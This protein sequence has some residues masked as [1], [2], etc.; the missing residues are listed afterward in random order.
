MDKA[1]TYATLL[2]GAAAVISTLAGLAYSSV[3]DRIKR[4][5]D[6]RE[7]EM[8]AVWSAIDEQ[9][10]DTKKILTSMVTKEDLNRSTDQLIKALSPAR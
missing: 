3:L 6:T 5:E 2:A 7:K 8:A 4:S 9:R 10:E 1:E